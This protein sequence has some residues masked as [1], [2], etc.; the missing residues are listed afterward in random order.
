MST[1]QTAP[2]PTRA[3]P[4][5]AGF[6]SLLVQVEPGAESAPRLQVAVDLARR[7][8]ATLIGVGLELIQGIGIGDPYVVGGDWIDE[9]EAM[10]QENLKRAEAS[11][12]TH[13]AGLQT[14][15]RAF[16]EIPAPALARLS[17]GAD[18]IVAGGAP[19]DN[20][21]RAADT[22]EVVLRSGRPVLVAPP[23]GGKLRGEA[24]VVAWKDT[25][26]SRRAVAD[27]LPF[28]RA[29][30]A[31]SVVEVC[32]KDAV[33]AA[34]LHT[35]DVVQYLRRHGVTAHAKAIVAPPEGVAA[36]LNAVARTI[37]A[38]LIVAGAYGR[39]RLGEWLFGGVTRS[40]LQEPE[41]FALLS[42]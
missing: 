13:A 20:F 28:L 26:E 42:H 34:E 17:R 36:E 16:H 24:V 30:E 1:V 40:L 25:R 10:V 33:A 18:L 6:R 38:D 14:E 4:A 7:F 32:D 37:D 41:R 9:L 22:A 3:A 19:L 2:A 8:D 15:W 11:F 12:R 35:S 23:R 29:A 31:V 39:T 27:S 5:A 21:T